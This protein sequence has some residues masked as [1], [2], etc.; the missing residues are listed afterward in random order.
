MRSLLWY[1]VLVAATRAQEPIS[2]KFVNSG[3]ADLTLHW[4]KPDGKIG[5]FLCSILISHNHRYVIIRWA[6]QGDG[7]EAAEWE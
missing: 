2:V 5:K 1:C 6:R 4:S 7:G 3:Y